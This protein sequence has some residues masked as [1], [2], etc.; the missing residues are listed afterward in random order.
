[1]TTTFTICLLEFEAKTRWHAPVTA[2]ALDS[3]RA[4]IRLM[5]DGKRREYWRSNHAGVRA[6]LSQPGVNLDD[7][8]VSRKVADCALALTAYHLLDL[9]FDQILGRLQG[10]VGWIVAKEGLAPV[11]ADA[12]LELPLA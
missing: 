10:G 2:D 3:F 1:M 4:T 5:T 6:L 9:T 8:D 12:L 7:P 11:P